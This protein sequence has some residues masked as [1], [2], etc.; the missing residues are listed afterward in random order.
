M[1]VTRAVLYGDPAVSNY[2]FLGEAGC[3]KSELSVNA[4][5]TMAAE[6][7]VV[8]FFDLDMTKP[9]FRSRDVRGLL[10]EHGVT[11]HFEEQF[12][13]A[14][15]TVGG[16]SRLLRSDCRVVMDIGGD[17]I[18]ARAVGAYA[19]LLN[20]GGSAVFYVV[21]PFRPWSADLEH[22]DATLTSVLGVSHVE[23][24]QLRFIS[25]PNLGPS[26]TPADVQC[27]HERVRGM[28]ED[29]VPVEALTV[30]E[31]LAGELPPELPLW[32]LKL[33]LGYEWELDCAN[34]NEQ[35]R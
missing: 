35:R 27:G 9:L 26:T 32:P 31:E 13:D 19:P 1:D 18:G 34:K 33:R 16:L 10:E 30:R 5:L 7:L 21:N 17:H 14:P 20:S 22:I 8:H 25:N 6:G 12:M 11:V 29:L 15:T 3:G 2:A 24:S 28:L 23:L 4:A